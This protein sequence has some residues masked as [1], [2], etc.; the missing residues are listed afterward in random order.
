MGGFFG[1]VSTRDV[2]LDV[3]FGVDYHSHLGTRRGGIAAWNPV[4]GFQRAI[5]SIENSPFRA[6]FENDV[7]R[8]EGSMCIGCISDLDPQP[9]LIRSHLGTYAIS[10][11][12]RINNAGELADEF[13]NKRSLHF[14]VQSG[15]VVNNTE[16]LAT[17]ID[18]KNTIPE[19]IAYA[20]SRIDGSACIIV[21]TDKREIY[22]ARDRMGRLP[23]MVGRDENGF[24]VSLES[25]AYQKLDYVDYKQLGP[26]EC[27]RITA[28]ECIT[29]IEASGREK[30]C[31]FMWTYFGYPNSH[32]EGESVE[33]IRNRGGEIMARNDDPELI[34]HI[35][36]V[37][38][39][40]DS[41]VPYAVGFS[42]E[43][44]VPFKRPFIK[45]TPTWPRS[46]MPD[47]QKV[48][49]HIAKM[50]MIPVPDLIRG[51]KLMFI[52]DSIVR[53]TQLQGTVQFLYDNGA[54]EVH[55]RSACPPIMFGC[56]Y[57]NFARNNSDMEL[58]SRRTIHELE[59]DEGSKHLEE[60]AGEDT[61]RGK[62]MRECICKK[63]GFDSLKFQT[64]DG[65]IE[66]I[67]IPRDRICTYCWTGEE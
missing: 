30:F 3:F 22:A 17:L 8:M 63:F 44:G 49:D 6:K 18:Q 16:L 28:D 1:A 37:C 9:I 45:Y 13:L 53:G 27:V 41:G 7:T 31:G 52:D 64:L 56:K 24:A 38:G 55:M 10:F 12:G 26:G 65:L 34:G 11:T 61:P 36:A 60:Y 66:S 19:G 5:H 51:K 46:F 47:S 59:G 14:D 54:E 62:Q 67:G 48:R 32:Y 4:D 20:Q 15:G 25:F 50:K 29:V 21:A 35:D 58:I 57:L 33:I 40:P 23:V 2:V 42:T 39:V 43:S